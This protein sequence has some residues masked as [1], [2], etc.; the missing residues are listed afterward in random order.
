M[1]TRAN[2][3]VSIEIMT[4]PH[5]DLDGWCL[6]E[7]IIRGISDPT[8]AEKFLHRF[9]TAV[10]DI[11]NEIDAAVG[12]VRVLLEKRCELNHWMVTDVEEV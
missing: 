2:R 9:G 4:I 11:Q 3:Q 1:F 8:P 5:P 6:V 10:K 7:G 12:A